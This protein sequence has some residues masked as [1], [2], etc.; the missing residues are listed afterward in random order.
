[1]FTMF[2]ESTM[3]SLQ[4]GEQLATDHFL[5][6]NSV[7]VRFPKSPLSGAGPENVRDPKVRNHPIVE[8]PIFLKK[9]GLN[10]TCFFFGRFSAPGDLREADGN[11]TSVLANM[12]CEL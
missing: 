12:S 1:M 3:R 8:S 4:K 5:V 10:K 11:L 7:F 9:L 2:Q 6:S